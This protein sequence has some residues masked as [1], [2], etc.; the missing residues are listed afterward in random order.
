VC[1]RNKEEERK[2]NNEHILF[3]FI[4]TS[5]LLN[6]ASRNDLDL[7][8]KINL[9][10]DN[11]RSLSYRELKDKFHISLRAVSNILKRKREYIDDFECNRNKKLKRKMKGDPGQTI[12]EFFQPILQK[13]P[14]DV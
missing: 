14:S 6:M 1:N 9:I 13:S 2:E 10:K 5:R 8:Q 4:F 12:Y 7:Q 3:L 11:E